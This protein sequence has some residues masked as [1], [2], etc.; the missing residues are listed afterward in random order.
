MA[1]AAPEPTT[2][3][4]R[5]APSKAQAASK[6]QKMEPSPVP[7]TETPS[8]P[9]SPA[10]ERK[11][12]PTKISDNTPLPTLP[13]AQS[14]ALS[15]SEYQSIAASA[16]LAASLERSRTKWAHDGVFERYWVNPRHY[17]GKNAK[18]LPPN[19]PDVKLQKSKGRCR[20]RIEP[21]IIEVDVY[22]EE[23]EKPKPVKQQQQQYAYGQGTFNAAQRP[24]HK[25]QSQLDG[26]G[27]PYYQNRTLPPIQQQR[28]VQPQQ[29]Q[30]HTPAVPHMR[31]Y[32]TP[33]RASPIPPQRAQHTPQPPRP[34]PAPQSTPQS[35]K[36]Q[37]A[38]PVISMLASRAS[39]DPELK[40]LMKEV[41]TGSATP[42]QLTVFQ[43]HIDELTAAIQKKKAAEEEA[44]AAEAK[45]AA[46]RQVTET[47]Q[48]DGSNDAKSPLKPQPQQPPQQNSQTSTPTPQPPRPPYAYTPQQQPQPLQRPAP[49]TTPHPPQPP[50]PPPP[51]PVLIQFVSPNATDDRFLFPR[52]SILETL[53]PQHTLVSFITTRFGRDAVDPVGLDPESE[54]WQPITMMVE[55]PYGREEIMKLVRQWVAP[56]SEVQEAMRGVMGRCER[57]P[58]AVLAM[59]LPLRGSVAANELG[60]PEA[61]LGV[62]LEEGARGDRRKVARKPSALPSALKKR[63]SVGKGEVGL[64]EAKSDKGE[65]A[66]DQEKKE[67]EKEKVSEDA[68]TKETDTDGKPK[69]A[70][71]E[72]KLGTSQ[73]GRPQRHVRKSVRISEI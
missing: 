3:Q 71:E 9:N 68:A 46:Q 51:N 69:E 17:T 7:A 29:S 44:A 18:N 33:H 70:N 45:A 32:D 28:P 8:L 66:V 6:K 11:R 52:H 15:D 1:T 64:A 21:H 61:G 36:K 53:S 19:N 2:G 55:V 16:V 54:Y 41:A 48:Y 13:E 37:S 72:G 65:V 39:S 62:G 35:D 47:I 58:E 12:L 59:R 5:A 14:A 30:Q 49:Y 40:G 56:V 50:L 42:E 63:G 57:A 38:D 10:P 23:K 73:S 31:Q 22:V 24:K 26:T 60:T 27:Q 4:K 67:K 34:A 25:G 20:L 43:R